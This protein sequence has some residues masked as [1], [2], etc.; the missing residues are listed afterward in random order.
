MGEGEWTLAETADLSVRGSRDKRG[1][2]LSG[3]AEW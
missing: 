1:A 3:G 2:F